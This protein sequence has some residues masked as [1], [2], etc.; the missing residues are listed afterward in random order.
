M[1]TSGAGGTG[2]GKISPAWQAIDHHVQ[3]TAHASPQ[4]RQPHDQN[5]PG[6]RIHIV[7]KEEDGG[8]G[9]QTANRDMNG[10]F[11]SCSG[12]PCIPGGIV[13]SNSQ[14]T[15]SARIYLSPL[16]FAASAVNY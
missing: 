11:P 16:L 2:I 9:K 1:S 4:G 6:K 15:Q 13:R 3:E 14:G 5:H 8:R 7:G 12:K 10:T